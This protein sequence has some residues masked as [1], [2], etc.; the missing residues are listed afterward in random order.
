MTYSKSPS[1]RAFRAEQRGAVLIITLDRQA[2]RNALDDPSIAELDAIVSAIPDSVRAIVLHGDSA[3]EELL[4]EE[5][6]DS[7]DVFVAVTNAE[8]ANILSAMSVAQRYNKSYDATANKQFSLSDQTV[9]VVKGLDKDVNLT[10]YDRT[11]AFTD[12]RGKWQHVTFDITMIDEEIFAEGTMFDGSSIA[13]WKAI[14]ESD[15]I[16]MPDASTAVLDPFFDDVTLIIRCD[17]IEP[18]D[19]AALASLSLLSLKAATK[20]GVIMRTAS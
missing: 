20:A 17:I 5:N 1:P 12:P 4:L 6:I 3:D 13:G 15:M 16:L 8:E 7:T 9:K 11:S 10:Y 18:A 19:I 14:N 2:K